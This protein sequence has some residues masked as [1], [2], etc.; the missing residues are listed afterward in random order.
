MTAAHETSDWRPAL[1]AR[2]PGHEF[3][4]IMAW[5]VLAGHLWVVAGSSGGE[6]HKRAH[7]AHRRGNTVDVI[8]ED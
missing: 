1:G 5:S 8:E 2:A 7:R 4:L 6:E 3:P